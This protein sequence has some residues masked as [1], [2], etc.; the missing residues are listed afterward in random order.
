MI[1]RRC[2]WHRRYFGYP[3]VCGVAGWAGRGIDFTD[4]MCRRC[5][6][7]IRRELRPP[8]RNGHRE[9][10]PPPR[11]DPLLVLPPAAAMVLVAGMILVVGRPRDSVIEPRQRPPE[12]TGLGVSAPP[13]APSP[14][15]HHLGRMA[16]APAAPGEPDAE[17]PRSPAVLSPDHRAGFPD[18]TPGP[19]SISGYRL[20]RAA[21]VGLPIQAP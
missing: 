19:A 13:P 2:A 10:H 15:R 16:E 9:P 18:F 12:S 14:A 20:A 17:S 11:W 8:A 4:W 5:A 1:L 3:I 7:R 6:A 21:G